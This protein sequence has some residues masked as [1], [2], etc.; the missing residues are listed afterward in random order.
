MEFKHNDGGRAETRKGDTGDCVCRAVA[1]ALNKPYEEIYAILAEGNAGERKTSSTRKKYGRTASH[2]I[3]THKKWFKDFMKS[4]GFQWVP[5]M[6]IGQGCTHH[7]R[8][9]EL[10]M[11]R[12][13][14]LVS[15]HAC[16]VIDGVIN[17]TY[18]PSRGGTRCVYGYYQLK[19]GNGTE[20]SK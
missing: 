11:G 8:D 14:V 10:P 17:D 2:G 4:V 18:D 16:A 6:K 1:I 19:E 5:T 20:N 15:R 12:L 9:G 13:I 7:L 3:Y